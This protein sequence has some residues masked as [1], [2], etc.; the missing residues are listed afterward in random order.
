VEV[1]GETRIDELVRML[2]GGGKQARGMAKSLLKPI[3]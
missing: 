2:G 3:S 1:T